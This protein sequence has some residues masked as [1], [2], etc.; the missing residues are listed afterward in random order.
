MVEKPFC[1]S[2]EEC[3]KLITLAKTQGRMLTVF[4]NRRWDADFVTLRQLVGD[5]KLGR[6]VEFESH[7]DR[8]DPDVPP[9]DVH[10]VPGAGAVFD[11][12]AHLLD[13]VLQLYGSPSRVTAF[14]S[15][16][17]SGA[18]NTGPSDAC[19]VL[20]HYGDGLL[21]TIKASPL[22]ADENQ[23]RFWVRGE[24]GSFKKYHLDPQEPQLVGGMTLEEEGFG[25]EPAE[26]AGEYPQP[27]H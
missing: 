15:H 8:F 18:S 17:R 24:K 5:N 23:L 11:L 10:D 7:F 2:S 19:T 3:D 13:Q 26:K 12:G 20:L 14:M 1:P 22:S 27:S 25:R 9:R 4:Q 21:A 6:V 16:Q